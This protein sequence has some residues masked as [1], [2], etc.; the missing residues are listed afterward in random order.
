[1]KSKDFFERIYVVNLPERTDRR[2][3]IV[4]EL[5]RVGLPL[6]SN[7]VEL[8]PAIKPESAGEFP[9]IGARGCFLSHLSILKQARQARLANVLIMEDDLAI[10]PLFQIYQERLIEQVK[11]SDWG[12]LYLGHCHRFED[13]GD[14]APFQ[15]K[16]FSGGLQTTHFYA[17]NGAILDRLIEFLEAILQRPYGHPDGGPMHVD[18]AYSHFRAQNPDVITL[19]ASPSLGMQQP[20][21]SDI[22]PNWLD[23]T[24]IFRDVVSAARFSKLW[25]QNRIA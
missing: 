25:L 7:R 17:I 5:E 6:T 21:R 12:F 1:M 13:I 3:M 11:Y 16:P 23:R 8:F 24:P 2:K 19:V 18:G 20:S 4:A 9:N 15:L 14:N 22:S 10:S